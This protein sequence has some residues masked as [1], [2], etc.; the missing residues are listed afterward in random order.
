LRAAGEIE[1]ESISKNSVILTRL[2]DEEAASETS[3]TN[4]MTPQLA[5]TP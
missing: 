3:S 5:A 2:P 4:V 1:M